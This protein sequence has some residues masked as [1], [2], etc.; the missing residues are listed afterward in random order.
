M[1]YQTITHFTSPNRSQGREGHSVEFIVIHWWNDPA[2]NPG[3]QGAI[4]TLC[5]PARQVSA[6]CVVEAGRVAWLVNANDTAW[7]SGNWATNCR[8]IGIEC[9]PRMSAADLETIA[10]LI[11]NLRRTYGPLPLYPHKQF[12]NT[13]CPGSYESKL[14]WLD[15]RAKEIQ[16]GTKPPQ[17]R[18][19][20]MTPEQDR[21]LTQILDL[22]TP[23]K[24]GVKYV[25]DIVARLDR[26]ERQAAQINALSAA[27][28]ALSK[29]NGLDGKAITEAINKAVTAAL[30]DVQ[31]TL[32][33]Q[34]ED[35]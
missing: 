15:Q 28:N 22:L 29:A 10:E 14:T 24:A 1:T 13:S 5:N 17:E 2:A 8:S 23:G 6:H 32:T 9:N 18:K 19:P 7:H 34:R 4:N 31:I 21:K 11:A 26:I 3:F 27:V 35:A 20:K 12:F 16:N 25:G 30:D 33:T